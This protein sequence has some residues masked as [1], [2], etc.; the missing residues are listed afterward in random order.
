MC[1]R[2]QLVCLKVSTYQ[3]K[4]CNAIFEDKSLGNAKD[5]KADVSRLFLKLEHSA[6]QNGWL[7]RK[8][9]EGETGWLCP[10]CKTTLNQV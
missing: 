3:Y 7:K 10:H 1:V 6:A 8:I 2:L 5:T 9:P 4:G